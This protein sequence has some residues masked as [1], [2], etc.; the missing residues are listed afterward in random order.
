MG[1]PWARWHQCRQ[2]GGDRW[3]MCELQAEQAH[4]NQGRGCAMDPAAGRRDADARH[5][6]IVRGRPRQRPILRL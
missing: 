3:A 4:Q 1:L 2:L 6:G 5:R